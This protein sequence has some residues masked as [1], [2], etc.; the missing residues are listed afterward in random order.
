VV[1]VDTERLTLRRP[2]Q[3]DLPGYRG[4]LLD[5][6]VMRWLRPP[7]LDPYD[8]ASVSDLLDR[9]LAHWA[10][11]GFGPAVIA[12]RRDG[13]FVGRGGLAWTTVAGEEA[14]ELPWAL[15]P[16]RWGEGLAT[17]AARAA[18]AWAGELGL[19]EVVSF[20]LTTNEAS[21]RVM[22]RIGLRPAGEIEHAGLPHVLYRGTP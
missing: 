10:R 2:T 14:V 22:E 15:M 3:D 13:S 9:D 8:D 4:L 21:R 18:L 1:A 5:P 12:D 17:E 11:H 6:L 20:T 7:P 19:A 16:A